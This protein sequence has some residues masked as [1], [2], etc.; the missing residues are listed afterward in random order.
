MQHYNYTYSI[1]YYPS[2][3]ESFLT[4]GDEVLLYLDFKVAWLTIN[5]SPLVDFIS[6][7]SLKPVLN[8]FDQK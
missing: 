8:N 1:F 6:K 5:N 4:T 7:S 2:S 3:S